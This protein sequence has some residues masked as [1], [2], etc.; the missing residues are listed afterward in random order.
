MEEEWR[1]DHEPLKGSVLYTFWELLY[2]LALRS[3]PNS[4]LVQFTV[5]G[6]RAPYHVIYGDLLSKPT[7]LSYL[8]NTLLVHVRQPLP[9]PTDQYVS[10]L[11]PTLS[12]G[13][14]QRKHVNNPLV[15][16]FALV[17]AVRTVTSSAFR[18]SADRS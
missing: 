4:S 9:S 5:I 15:A 13:V 16:P 18:T 12:Y 11:P 8:T 14:Y 3:R 6:H 7:G 10:H 17:L 2:P 1:G